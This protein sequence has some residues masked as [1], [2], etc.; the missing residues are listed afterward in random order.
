MLNPIL[1][2]LAEGTLKGKVIGKANYL[3]SSYNKTR[4]LFFD[5]LRWRPP[6]ME[7]Q[8]IAA[9]KGSKAKPVFPEGK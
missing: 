1:L 6:F 3:S 7:N 8:E 9:F 2:L 5:Y 4:S